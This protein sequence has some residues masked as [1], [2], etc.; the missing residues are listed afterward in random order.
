MPRGSRASKGRGLTRRERREAAA[1]P[2]AVQVG[3][4]TDAPPPRLTS[5]RDRAAA[6]LGRAEP[7]VDYDRA[8]KRRFVGWLAHDGRKRLMYSAVVVLAGFLTLVIGVGWWLAARPPAWWAEVDTASDEVVSISRAV[9]NWAVS[10]MTRQHPADARWAVTIDE[11]EANAWL[12]VRLPLWVESEYGPWPDRIR[13]VRIRFH[14]GR[15]IV[16]A[17]IREPGADQPRVVAAALELDV[18]QDGTARAGIGWTQINRLKLPGAIG[19][20]RLS[21]WID[22]AGEGEIAAGLSELVRGELNAESL[23]WRLEDGRVVTVH[24]IDVEGGRLRLTCSTSA[25]TA[26]SQR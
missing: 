9:E 16:G 11:A 19:L 15:V 8:P 12:A 2:G 25:A 14:D 5:R 3:Q 22:S 10:T 18:D 4:P 17:D 26:R 21:D 23:G 13:S 6:R 1:R 7:T 20:K 24:A